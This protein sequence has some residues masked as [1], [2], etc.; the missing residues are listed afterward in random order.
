MLI[1]DV[2]IRGTFPRFTT[3]SVDALFY[4][5]DGGIEVAPIPALELGAQASLVRAKNVKDGSYLV[6]VPAD[7]YRGSVTY[8]APDLGSFKS[9]FATVSGTY[10]ARQ[11]RYDPTADFVAPPPAYFLLGAELG[12]KTQLAD[13]TVRFAVQ[14]SNLTNSR[15]R[16]YTSLMRYFADEPGWQVW[17][18]MSVFFDS[19]KKGQ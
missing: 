8:H 9:S 5:A 19:S 10:V 12:T 1:Y 17:L 7:H 13:Q 4:G 18:R 15:Y 3:Q 2:L 14:G 16:D 11:H 6:F